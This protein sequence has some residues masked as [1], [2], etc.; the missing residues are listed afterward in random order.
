MSPLKCDNKDVWSGGIF[1]FVGLAAIIFALNLPMGTAMRMGPAYF[2]TMLGGLLTLIGIAVIVRGL[3]RPGIPVGQVAFGK[4]ALVTVAIILFGLLL[5]PLG[6][7]LSIVILVMLSALASLR[8]RWSVA[9]T[10][11]IGLAI[12]SSISFAWLLGLPFPILG[13][14]LGGY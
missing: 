8:F 13:I 11:A 7:V 2:P 9:L 1:V 12:F 3:V 6:L 14:W 5:R 10:L 4:I